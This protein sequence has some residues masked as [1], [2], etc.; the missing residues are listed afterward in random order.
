MPA[1]PS[2]GRDLIGPGLGGLVALY[3]PTVTV[4]PT[5]M[6]HALV[7]LGAPTVPWASVGYLLTAALTAPV[8]AVL[9]RRHPNSMAAASA[10]LMIVGSSLS[11]L[12]P[13]YTLLLAG[14]TLSGLGAGALVATAVVLALRVGGGRAQTIGLTAG[15]GTFAAVLGPVLGGVLTTTI[16]WRMVFLISLPPLILTL[17]AC[18]AGGIITVTDRPANQ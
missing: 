10:G 8:G 15:L 13:S 12:V 14:Q 5:W 1:R 18:L 6:D 4:G 7:D 2:A 16:G 9:G 17:L 3:L 11:L